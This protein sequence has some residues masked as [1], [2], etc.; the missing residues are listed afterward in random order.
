MES[1]A[2][3][4]AP[5]FAAH[6]VRESMQHSGWCQNKAGAARRQRN[7]HQY[8]VMRRIW[9]S[10]EYAYSDHLVL[11]HPIPS[12]VVT[13]DSSISPVTTPVAV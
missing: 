13:K 11:C 4:D 5:E 1:Q 3:L 9:S 7:R 2:C 8:Q 6:H 10:T 12:T